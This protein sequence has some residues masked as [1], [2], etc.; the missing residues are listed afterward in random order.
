VAHMGTTLHFGPDWQHDAWYTATASVD[1]PTGTFH[2]EFHIF[3]FYWDNTTMYS[4]LDKDSNRI[5]SI[6]TTKQSFWQRGNFSNNMHN[7]WGDQPN[8]APFNQD[9]YLIFNVAVGGTNGYFPDGLG[10]K[11]WTDTS[12]NSVNEFYNGKKVWGQTWNGEDSAL[13]IDW[14]KAYSLQTDKK[15]QTQTL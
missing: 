9:Y 3:G 14:V 12:P 8:V 2:D 7:P 10:G 5:L 1:L 6:D 4:Y 11:P 15:Q 13:Q